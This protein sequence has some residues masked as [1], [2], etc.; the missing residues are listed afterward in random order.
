MMAVTLERV[1]VSSHHM[2]RMKGEKPSLSEDDGMH[3]GP[4]QHNDDGED[5]FGVGVGG[6]VAKTDGSQ[7]GSSEVQGSQV[8]RGD[9]RP[10]QDIVSQARRQLPQPACRS[11]GS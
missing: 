5:F 8:R 2:S 1:K 11:K 7:A 3:E 4:N 10:V 6:H 9:V